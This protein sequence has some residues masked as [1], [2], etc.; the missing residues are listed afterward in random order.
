MNYLFVDVLWPAF[1][2]RDGEET[3]HAVQ[4]VIEVQVAVD[5]LALAEHHVV[6]SVLLMFYKRSPESI[7]DAQND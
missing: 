3:Q 6:K 7:T 1:K 4:D 2:C 5:P